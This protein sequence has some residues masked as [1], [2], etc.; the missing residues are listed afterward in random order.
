MQSRFSNWD[1][2]GMRCY[3]SWS[4]ALIYGEKENFIPTPWAYYNWW[5]WWWI[6]YDYY[7]QQWDIFWNDVL[8]P[9]RDQYKGMKKH[10][11]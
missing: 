6:S 1:G 4:G 5:S 3:Y 8:P 2:S 9:L 7:R 10:L 11:K